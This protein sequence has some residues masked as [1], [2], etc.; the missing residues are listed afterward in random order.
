MIE[1]DIFNVKFWNWIIIIFFINTT[2]IDYWI[3]FI[4]ILILKLFKS[5][6]SIINV[7]EFLIK[8]FE[9]GYSAYDHNTLTIWEAQFG[10]FANTCQVKCIEIDN[11]FITELQSNDS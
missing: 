10:D 9:L 5:Y 1:F 6:N 8:G 3:L 11:F 7:I 4:L 2:S